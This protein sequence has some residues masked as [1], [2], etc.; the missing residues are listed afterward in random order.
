LWMS[1]HIA[2]MVGGVGVVGVAVLQA[3]HRA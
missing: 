1:F 2:V 3:V